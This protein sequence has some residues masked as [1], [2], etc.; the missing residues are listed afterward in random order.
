MSKTHFNFTIISHTDLRLVSLKSFWVF[1]FRNFVNACWT[2]VLV[3][4]SNFWTVQSIIW[5]WT[6]QQFHYD[7]SIFAYREKVEKASHTHT[8]TPQNFIE[9]KQAT[10]FGIKIYYFIN[11]FAFLSSLYLHSFIH[12]VGNQ[13]FVN[14]A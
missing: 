8:H 13:S 12:D 1:V 6:F 4:R 5:M 2:F 14:G 11:H 3:R 9:P 10:A 7:E